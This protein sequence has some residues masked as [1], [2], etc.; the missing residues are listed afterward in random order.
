[1]FLI[2][3]KIS[4]VSGAT[5]VTNDNK[6]FRVFANVKLSFLSLCEQGLKQE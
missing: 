2:T 1:M 4:R 5:K 6:I 3:R